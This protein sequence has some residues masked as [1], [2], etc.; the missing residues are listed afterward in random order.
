MRLVQAPPPI[1]E[2]GR[3]LDRMVWPVVAS[4]RASGHKDKKERTIIHTAGLVVYAT[5]EA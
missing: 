2:L 3:I 4:Y 1:S 5:S